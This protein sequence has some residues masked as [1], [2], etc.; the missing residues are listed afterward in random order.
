M[1]TF[2]QVG[3]G[4]GQQ[5]RLR[6]GSVQN[7]WENQKNKKKQRFQP[8]P[9]AG[10]WALLDLAQI[11]GFFV[12]FCFFGFFDGFAYVQSGPIPVQ[13]FPACFFVFLVGWHRCRL[14]HGLAGAFESG[15]PVLKGI[16]DIRTTHIGEEVAEVV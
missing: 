15:L 10:R 12:F 14:S 2:T 1:D 5:H 6:I 8:N 3:A 13:A 16:I 7:S 4:T 9:R 11:F